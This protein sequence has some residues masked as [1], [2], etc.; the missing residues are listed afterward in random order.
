MRY[1]EQSITF[2][3][4]DS[5]I[6][7]LMGMNLN[8]PA[9]YP[10]VTEM[11]ITAVADDPF[12]VFPWP[13]AV[14]N[15]RGVLC[16]DVF[17]ALYQNFQRFLTKQEVNKFPK[18]KAKLVEEAFKQRMATRQGMLDKENDDHQDGLRRIDYFADKVMFRGL[19][20][21]M[22]RGGSWIL[23]LGPHG[24]EEDLDTVQYLPPPSSELRSYQLTRS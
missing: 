12:P 18:F 16:R 23:F 2:A 22:D 17:H 20:P 8:Q 15:K 21:S 7:P 11:W 5:R 1:D 19:E 6:I 24:P 10:F 14:Y 4:L 3:T 9:T 13:V